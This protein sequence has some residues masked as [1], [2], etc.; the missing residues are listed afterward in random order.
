MNSYQI[1]PANRDDCRKIAELYSISSDGV[2]DYIWTQLASPG[3][4]ILE[5]GARR[6]EREGILF[7]YQNCTIVEQAGEIIGM[8]WRGKPNY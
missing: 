3:E 8:L 5:V 6:Y 1:R 7:S 4:D 2:A